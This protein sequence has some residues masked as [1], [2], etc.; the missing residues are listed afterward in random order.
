MI[1]I[2]IRRGVHEKENLCVRWMKALYELALKHA[3]RTPVPFIAGAAVLLVMTGLLF[4]GL[5][6]VFIP[7]A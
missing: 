5:G 7:S 3:I 6:Q 4:T 2:F 1:A